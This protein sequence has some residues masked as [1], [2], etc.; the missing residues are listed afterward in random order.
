MNER[1]RFNLVHP[2][3]RFYRLTVIGRSDRRDGKN[4]CW[5]CRCDCG[6]ETVVSTGQ[7]RRGTSKSC[8]CLA[9]E[10]ARARKEHGMADTPVY[11]VWQAMKNRC[12]NPKQRAYP[13]YGGRGISVCGRWRE[14][15]SSFLSDMGMP[16]TGMSLDRIDND[17]NYEP[18]NCR[19]A[20]TL[21]QRHNR[22][23]IP[24]L[25][26][27]QIALRAAAVRRERRIA[28]AS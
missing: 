12:Y 7:L 26:R 11:R 22:R 10:L 18:G 2:G 24:P 1:G 19:W 8:G 13:Y 23:E 15:F 16:P 4:T 21:Q 28:N 14:S 6:R 5:H 27:R 9:I 3:D 25:E 17:G 20:T